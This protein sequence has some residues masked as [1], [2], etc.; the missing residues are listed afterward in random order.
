[1]SNLLFALSLSLSLYM[2]CAG[3]LITVLPPLYNESLFPFLFPLGAGASNFRPTPL[4]NIR[5]L[6]P[7]S[8]ACVRRRRKQLGEILGNR[9]TGLILPS[10]VYTRLFLY[11]N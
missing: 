11:Y 6:P 7:F 8:L 5:S 10:H 9:N 2:L 1:M 3:V 4:Y